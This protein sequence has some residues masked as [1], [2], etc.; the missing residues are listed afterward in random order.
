MV[1]PPV[2]RNRDQRHGALKKTQRLVWKLD[3]AVIVAS[4]AGA[5][6]WIEHGHRIDM[7]TPT[8]ETFTS[9]LGTVCPDN[10]NVPY[11][12]DCIV[13]MHGAGAS[14]M[15]WRANAAGRSPA[16]QPSPS[17]NVELTEVASG[18][19]CADNDNMPYTARCVAFIT[20]W[21]W[22]PNAPWSAPR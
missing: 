19:A 8:G 10:E 1:V 2:R 7:G 12:T 18:S 6:L 5:V 22:R 15:P 14:N 13:F 20:G 4:I 3:L 9:P 21:F 11:N 16:E 17:K